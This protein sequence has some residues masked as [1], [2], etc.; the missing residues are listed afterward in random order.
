MHISSSENTRLVTKLYRGYLGSSAWAL[1]KFAHGLDE[2]KIW[3]INVVVRDKN[4]SWLSN[5]YY[6]PGYQYSWFCNG[7]FMHITTVSNDASS[8]IALCPYQVTITYEA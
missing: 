3:S 2:S 8:N 4:G 5:A 1:A 6:H 7:G